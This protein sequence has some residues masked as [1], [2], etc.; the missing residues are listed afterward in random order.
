MRANFPARRRSAGDQ[1]PTRQGGDG[2]ARLWRIGTALAVSFTVAAV[3]L[4][5]LAW[6]AWVL[7]ARLGS[8]ATGHPRCT[9]PW[10]SCSSFS[11][12]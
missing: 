3:G 2:E 8:G 5:G 6:L 1:E 4:V 12:R 10:G 11:R 7:L 9:T